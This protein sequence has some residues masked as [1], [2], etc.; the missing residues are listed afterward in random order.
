M[1]SGVRR[2][3]AAAE[4]RGTLDLLRAH[5]VPPLLPRICDTD[6]QRPFKQG[7]E[8][9]R[10]SFCQSEGQRSQERVEASIYGET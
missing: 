6:T 3:W 5:F 8:L 10:H 2:C 7:V 4:T 1:A 9:G